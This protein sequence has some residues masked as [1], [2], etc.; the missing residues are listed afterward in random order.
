MP[1]KFHCFPPTSCAFATTKQANFTVT[2]VVYQDTL[3][4]VPS[5]QPGGAAPPTRLVRS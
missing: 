4:I 5:Y 2:E 1:A 3:L